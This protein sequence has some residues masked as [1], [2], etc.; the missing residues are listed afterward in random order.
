MITLIALALIV[1]ALANAYFVWDGV[2]ILVRDPQHSPL[3]VAL[4]AAKAVVWAFGVYLAVLS[5]AFLADP[6]P[7]PT[8]GSGV[9]FGLFAVLLQLLPGFVHLQ[10]RRIE[11]S[12]E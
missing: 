10:M 11:R 5:A 9:A 7:Q 6:H 3:L 8:T 2:L 1:L 4:L 12:R